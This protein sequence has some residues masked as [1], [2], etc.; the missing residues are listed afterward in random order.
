MSQPSEVQTAVFMAT[1][2]LIFARRVETDCKNQKFCDNF[3]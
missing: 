1:M 2:L 3:P